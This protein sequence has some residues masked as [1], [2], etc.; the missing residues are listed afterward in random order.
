[1][2]ASLVWPPDGEDLALVIL[3]FTNIFSNP[4][5]LLIG[6]ELGPQVISDVKDVSF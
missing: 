5:T 6:I 1:M 3:V 2:I 4:N